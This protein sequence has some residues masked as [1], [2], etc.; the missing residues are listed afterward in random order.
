M[1][2]EIGGI[3]LSRIHKITTLEQADFASHRVPGLE[4]NIV[5]NMGR[6]SVRLRIEGIHYG[7]EAKENLEALREIYKARQEIDF[8]ADIVGEAYFSEVIIETF[9]VSQQAHEPDQYSFVLTVA[10]YVPPPEP[11][12]DFGLDVPGVD[13]LIALEALDFMDL[14]QLPDLLGSV[15]EISDPTIPLSGL[16]DQVKGPLESLDAIQND[17]NEL[18]GE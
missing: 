4:G 15:P 18:F 2:I 9:E 6:N 17:I 14:V 1:P 16:I 7:S 12:S 5:Q 11:L 8:L 3:N 10:E 13:E